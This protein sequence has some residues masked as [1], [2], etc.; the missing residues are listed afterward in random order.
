MLENITVYQQMINSK[1]NY[2]YLIGIEKS[3]SRL[4]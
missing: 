2:S 3:E 1:E 4:V